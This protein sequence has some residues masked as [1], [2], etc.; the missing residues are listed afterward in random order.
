MHQKGLD[1]E[2]GFWKI[3]ESE[4]SQELGIGGVEAPWSKKKRCLIISLLVGLFVGGGIV[5]G[6]ILYSSGGAITIT[7]MNRYNLQKD[8]S[9]PNEHYKVLNLTTTKV[10]NNFP[11]SDSLKTEFKALAY[12]LYMPSE[13]TFWLSFHP[14]EYNE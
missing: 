7:S 3:N 4:Y 2:D 14:G 5:L 6:I 12:N 1:D 9:H 11:F 13:N 10:I 8:M